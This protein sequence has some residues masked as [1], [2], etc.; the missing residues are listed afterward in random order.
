MPLLVALSI[1]FL[2]V[3]SPPVQAQAQ[4]SPPFSSE[5]P[6]Q[7]PDEGGEMA[8]PVTVEKYG[9]TWSN[10]KLQ[11]P[12]AVAPGLPGSIVDSY[13]VNGYGQLLTTLR[14]GEVC[15]LVVSFNAPGYFYLWEYYPPGATPYGHWLCYRWYRPYAGV[16]KIGP[17]AAESFEP[18]GRYTWKLW[19]LS[20]ASW[21]ARTLSF[22]YIKGYHP[23]DIPG[24]IIPSPTPAPT[25]SPVINSFS[26][27]KSSIEAGE[28]AVL[29]W[30]T[31]NA[32]SVNISPGVGAVAAS[33]ST[34][35]T[36]TTTT[37]YTLTASS[38]SGNPV[39]AT[40][41]ITVMP[42]IPP[43]L[44]TSQTTIQRG[45]ATPLSWN[46][47]GA[48]RVYITSVGDVGAKGTTQIAPDKTA[49][50]ALAATYV[51]GTT[52]SAVVTVNVEQ[53]PYMLWGLIALLAVAAIVIIVLLP[54]KPTTA[55]QTP[56]AATQRGHTAPAE[57]TIPTDTL[58]STTP[59]TE[60]AS[61]KLGMPDGSEILLAGNARSFG[62][63]DFGKSIPPGNI[64]YISRQHFNIWYE[65]DHYYIEDRSS[66]NGT[67]V[68][69]EDIKGTGRHMLADGDVI[70]L[71]G[72]L[73]ITFKG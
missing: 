72:K 11:Q 13:L 27:N 40:T 63:H 60:T 23:P 5:E 12:M 4:Q 73:S 15:Y 16:W 34:T 50:Y 36:P 65:G 64:S 61:A 2:S 67:K 38:K 25:P 59:V 20:G 54:R 39:S 31:T 1:F 44:I 58:P 56:A 66:T 53:P 70:E 43:T 30:N 26:V 9:Q 35:A 19:F 10:L 49:T 62:R 47:P 8:P 22:N 71:A 45:Q 17:F 14:S 37:I 29:T 51:D 52:Q 28:T 32:N 68:N 7:P 24:I 6:W 42:R 46:A 57:V 41:T 69:G 48:L 33:G 21:S 55:C 3:I 18:S